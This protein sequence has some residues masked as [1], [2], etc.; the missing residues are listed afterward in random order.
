MFFL[1]IAMFLFPSFFSLAIH[2]YLKHGENESTH[3]FL[4][5]KLF[6]II[7]YRFFCEKNL[8]AIESKHLFVQNI[9]AII[10]LHNDD[11]L[12]NY[13]ELCSWS[14]KWSQKQI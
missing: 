4:C 13:H 14:G 7:Y 6:W 2:S 12:C 10:L 3:I 5:R 11:M 8:F 9:C 1:S